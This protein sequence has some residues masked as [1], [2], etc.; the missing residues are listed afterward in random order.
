MNPVAKIH[1]L[2]RE[3]VRRSY[4]IYDNENVVNHIRV[5]ESMFV[6]GS[7]IEFTVERIQ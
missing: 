6:Q 7:I 4:A 2:T 5:M 1:Y 3:R